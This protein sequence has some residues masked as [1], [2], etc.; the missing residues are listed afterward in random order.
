M[1]IIA[2]LAAIFAI[3]AGVTHH[4]WQAAAIGVGVL[5][6]VAVVGGRKSA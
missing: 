1:R 2:V 6:L 3:Y 4:V 5:I